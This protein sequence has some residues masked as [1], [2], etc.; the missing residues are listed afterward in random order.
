MMTAEI[1]KHRRKQLPLPKLPYPLNLIKGKID[2]NED[3]VLQIARRFGG[4]TIPNAHDAVAVWLYNDGMEINE[5]AE[6]LQLSKDTVHGYI[7][8]SITEIV[9]GGSPKIIK[10]LSLPE[11]P[12]LLREIMEIIDKYEE[13]A[14]IIS[15]GNSVDTVLQIAQQFGGRPI[16]Y[17]HNVLAVFLWNQDMKIETIAK[18][19]RISK[20]VVCSYL[21]EAGLKNAE[22]FT[23]EPHILWNIKR[24]SATTAYLTA[25]LGG[26]F[27]IHRFY[28]GKKDSAL[29]MFISG[30]LVPFFFMI[31]IW[32]QSISFAIFGLLTLFVHLVIL[33]HDLICLSAMVE[34][35][36]KDLAKEI[37][38]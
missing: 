30:C 10:P 3:C 35:H 24:K 36:N 16:P 34:K 38:E 29:L 1:L 26:F 9:T 14:Y 33:A 25:F 2:E 15:S 31:W 22:E 21:S 32:G 8:N 28:L 5:I 18:E 13:D 19:L 17:A 7:S 37:L 20:D 23:L 11:L 27:G 6:Q 12:F 4:D